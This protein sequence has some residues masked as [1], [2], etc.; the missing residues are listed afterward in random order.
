M[1][2][3]IRTDPPI[4]TLI[5]RVIEAEIAAEQEINEIV[6]R[7]ESRFLRFAYA[8]APKKTGAYAGKIRTRQLTVANGAGFEVLSP[9]PL[10]TFIQKGTK[11]H[12]IAARRAKALR[13]FWPK[14]GAMVYVPKAGGFRTHFR[15]GALWIGKGYVNHPGTK[16]NP[17]MNAAYRRWRPGAQQDL[18]KVGLRWAATMKG[19][20]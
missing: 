16:A 20:R 7:Q 9:G 15:G 2:I 4:A 17:F 5:R 1:S 3:E 12:T 18:N 6:R 11:P 8:A 19:Q 13:F 14:I 10:G